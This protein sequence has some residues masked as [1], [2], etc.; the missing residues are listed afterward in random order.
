MV[1][2]VDFDHIFRRHDIS[3]GVTTF[4]EPKEVPRPKVD[5]PNLT[6]STWYGHCIYGVNGP[7]G[8]TRTENQVK[9]ELKEK[10]ANAPS[11]I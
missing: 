2:R 11:K 9:Y 10:T 4:V 7:I 3:S 8:F 5:D 6:S 1:K